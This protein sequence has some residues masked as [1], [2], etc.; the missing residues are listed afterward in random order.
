[1]GHD[2]SCSK[3]EFECS[4]IF[5][6]Q[7][8]PERLWQMPTWCSGAN[9]KMR[10]QVIVCNSVLAISAPI[11]LISQRSLSELSK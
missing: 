5:P 4:R 9:M 11:D 10:R 3:T 2:Q 8:A 1:M 6:I 7:L